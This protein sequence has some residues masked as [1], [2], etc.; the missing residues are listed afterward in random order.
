MNL[1]FLSRLKIP[2]IVLGWATSTSA[3]ALTLIFQGQFV[4][5]NIN[6]GGLYPEVTNPNPFLLVGFYLASFAISALAG[7]VIANAGRTISAFFPAYIGAAAL[8]WLILALPDFVVVNDPQQVLQETATLI[9][10]TAFFPVFLLTT[11]T[12]ALAGIGLEESLL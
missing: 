4:P 3:L 1:R 2:L 11:L 12:G 9:T 5:R 10:F 8:T 7:M 6:G